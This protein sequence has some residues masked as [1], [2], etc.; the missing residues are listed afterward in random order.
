MVLEVVVPDNG[1]DHS[2]SMVSLPTER[3]R[4]QTRVVT[5]GNMGGSLERDVSVTR[6]SEAVH[7]R[8]LVTHTRNPSEVALQGSHTS[9]TGQFLLGT[10]W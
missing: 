7:S 9:S 4:M 1:Q 6:I 8:A 3:E 5:S 2:L 10:E